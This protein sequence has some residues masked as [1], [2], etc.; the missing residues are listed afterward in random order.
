[1]QIQEAIVAFE[2]Y[3]QSYR[4]DNL[5]SPL[6]EP[7]DYILS[8][9]GKRIRPAIVIWLNDLYNGDINNGLN[10]ALAIEMFH[11]FSLVHD[12]IM[13]EAPLRRG[14]ETVH[15]KWNNN[16]AILSGDAM[17]VLVYQI[18]S[19]LD[20]DQL[21]EALKLFNVSALNVCEGQQLDMEFESQSTISLDSYIN[22]IG[23]KTGDLLGASFALGALL[24]NASKE[25]IENL[26]LFGKLTGVAFQLQDDI[27]DLYGEQAKVGKQTGGD[28][29]ANKK[30][31]LWIR[32]FEK[33]DKDQLKEL[34]KMASDKNPIS[35]VDKAIELF[36]E[37]GVKEEANEIKSRFQ[38][39]ALIHLN[40]INLSPSKKEEIK[41]F[42]LLLLGREF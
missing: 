9:G 2:G 13:D 20:K 33:A 11:N 28:I 4:E 15:S 40:A 42:S 8:L 19:E 35:K 14:K 17:L 3:L 22:M 12:D 37:L 32:A 30:T 6:L 29:L 1:M 10:A 31:C 41:N 36:N 24:A 21:K 23:L 7:V 34:E 18:L 5:N 25:D 27:L 26:Y 39:D 38:E 16:A